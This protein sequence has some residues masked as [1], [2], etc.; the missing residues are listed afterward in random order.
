MV[1]ILHILKWPLVKQKS[2]GKNY[3]RLQK[4]Y[5]QAMGCALLLC[6]VASWCVMLILVSQ[7][8]QCNDFEHVLKPDDVH[9]GLKHI[10]QKKTMNCECVKVTAIELCAG[11]RIRAPVQLISSLEHIY[12][13]SEVLTAVS[14]KMVVFWVVVPC[15]LVEVYQHFRGPCCPHHQGDVM[16]EAARTS[17]TL[18][19][20]YQTTRRYNSEDSHLHI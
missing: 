12:N 14:A 11:W 8:S 16:M 1:T 6:S 20:V 17:E 7:L 15:S 5:Q 18:V 2:D 13:R 9:I 4:E 10:V 3:T 19:N